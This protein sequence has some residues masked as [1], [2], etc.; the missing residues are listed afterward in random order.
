M[1]ILFVGDIVGRV[2]RRVLQSKLGELRQQNKIDCVIANGENAAGGFG[3]TE[4]A[5]DEIYQSGVDII[6]TGNHIWDKK[7]AY[8]LLTDY[9]NL[10]R[11]YNFPHNNPGKGYCIWE[12]T[13]GFKLAILNL[14]GRVFMS[15][16]DCPFRAA[17]QAITELSK[18]TPNIIVDFHGE[19]TSEKKAF[20]YY[21]NGRVTAICGTHTHVQTSDFQVS[22]KKTAY[23]T[24]VGMTGAKESI[25]GMSPQE[26]IDRFLTG[27]PHRFK[28]A[29]G[30][31]QINAA[32]IEIDGFGNALRIN[33]I[34]S[35]E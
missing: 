21:V 29:S 22:D 23:V 10:I 24:D 6:T 9:S 5:I 25:I 8:H 15:P 28:V 30:K 33:P 4:K 27:I 3:I 16:N 18:I 14:M 32:L 20:F 12:S 35:M 13:N 26:V 2:G 11:P 1:K 34:T 31:G 17:D 7:D 19:A